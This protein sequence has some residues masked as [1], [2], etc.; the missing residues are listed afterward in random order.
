MDGT[1]GYTDLT[2]SAGFFFNR[3][4]WWFQNQDIDRAGRYTSSATK[5]SKLIQD[6]IVSWCSRHREDRV[7]HPF[8]LIRTPSFPLEIGIYFQTI[9]K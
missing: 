7:E 9:G 8:S 5:T 4:N 3:Y 6:Q 2:V 1:C